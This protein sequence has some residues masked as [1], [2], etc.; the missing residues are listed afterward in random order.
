MTTRSLALRLARRVRHGTI[1]LREGATTTSFGAGGPVVHVDIRD[2]RFYA[3]LLRGS[4]GLGEAYMRGWWDCDDLTLLA[5]MLIRNLAGPTRALDSLGSSIA[6]LRDAVARR[7]RGRDRETD[8]RNIHAHYD[9]GND[10][11]ALMLEPSMMYSCGVFDRVDTTLADAQAA[12]LDRICELLELSS[13]DHVLEIGTGWGGFAV[14]AATAYGCR[15]TTTTISDAQYEYARDRVARAGLDGV[16]T[17]LNADYRDLAG[18]YDKLASIEMIEAIDWRDY[19]S[20]FATCARLLRPGGRAALQ[21]IV[22]TEES[23]HRAKYHEDFIRRFIFPGGCLPSIGAITKTS[24][25]AG[26]RL[27]A[28]QDIGEHYPATL[29]AWRANLDGNGAEVE[30]QGLPVEFRRMWDLYLAYCEAAFL[31][32][33]VSDVQLLLRVEE[34]AAAVAR[35]GSSAVTRSNVDGERASA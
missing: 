25:R 18:T 26:F 14:H 27:C 31:E 17:V 35:V 19:E 6:P 23:F 2:R 16:V 1:V 20:F 4:R 8:R 32:R 13:A 34:A 33:R 7:K 24:S 3:A 29:R 10:F 9:I 21:A 15:V 11:Y 30:A 22:I 28:L 5:R 12:K